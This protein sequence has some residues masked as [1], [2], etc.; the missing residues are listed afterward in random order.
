MPVFAWNIFNNGPGGT[1]HPRANPGLAASGTIRMWA[2]LDGVNAPVY[3]DAA[4]TIVATDQDGENAMEF[5]RVN[6]MWVAGTGWVDYFNM[7][8]VN[9]NGDWQYINLYI[10]VYGETVHVLL[11]NGLFEPPVV[12]PRIISVA[13]NPVVVEQGGE[14][15]I[16]VTTQGMPDGAWVDLNV[17]WRPGL[18]IVG[19]PRFYVVDDQAII[20]I[21]ADADARLGRDGFAVAARATGD[22]GSVV[23]LSSY[24]FVIDVQ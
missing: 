7:V 16:V 18:S 13:P 5:I 6:R 23:I 10:T 14:V 1:Q 19:G 4:D 11:A 3:L 17:A 15:E 21:A 2:Q 8:N 22:W 9:K 12:I 24:S 20:T